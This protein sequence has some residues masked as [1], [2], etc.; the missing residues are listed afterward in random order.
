[1]SGVGKYLKSKNNDI[2][3]CLTDPLG[4]SIVNY[5]RYNEIRSD[6]NESSIAEG[7]GLGGRISKQIDGFKPD[8]I[9][10]INDTEMM[11]TLHELQIK[12][13]LMCGLSTG[14]NVAGAIKMARKLGYNKDNIVVTILCDKSTNYNSKQFNIKYLKDL[15]LP[16]PKW[17]QHN[18]FKNDNTFNDLVKQTFL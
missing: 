13:G 15:G 4:G 7:I 16:T 14:I 11:N 10:E 3:I 12:D 1:M 17:I 8:Y 5:Y 9:L 6:C 18:I 2:K